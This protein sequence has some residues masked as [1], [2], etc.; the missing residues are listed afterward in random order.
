M[1]DKRQLKLIKKLFNIEKTYDINS[2]EEAILEEELLDLFEEE[3]LDKNFRSNVMELINK[4]EVEFKNKKLRKNK[5]SLIAACAVII[6]LIIILP[7]NK[8]IVDALEQWVRNITISNKNISQTFKSVEDI[9]SLIDRNEEGKLDEYEKMKMFRPICRKEYTN[10]NSK[11]AEEYLKNESII[12]LYKVGDLELHNMRYQEYNNYKSFEYHFLRRIDKNMEDYGNVNVVIGQ[13]EEVF[14]NM[15]T[16]SKNSEFKKVK[17]LSYEGVFENTTSE[18][19]SKWA[20]SKSIIVPI[21]EEKIEVRLEFQNYLSEN[22]EKEVIKMMEQIIKEIKRNK[23]L[24]VVTEKKYDTAKEG[25][26]YIK[27]QSIIELYELLGIQ[28]DSMEYKKYT[29]K[30]KF[31]YLYIDKNLEATSSKSIN[32]ISIDITKYNKNNSS[33]ISVPVSNFE[34]V[35]ILSYDGIFM[36]PFDDGECLE[37]Y[38]PDKK[39][40][41]HLSSTN[42][43]NKVDAIKAM[44]TI[45]RD[46]SK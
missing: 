12:Q 3:I 36:T 20:Y 17:V 23:N 5:K 11:E 13:H 9:E 39:I 7:Y 44:E 22:F 14:T 46:I 15:T 1:H 28:L 40:K 4:E 41:I 16:Y 33:N 42:Y 43:I 24:K 30:E 19:E 32:N 35:K 8:V 29:T 45:I 21:P 6:A 34:K 38:M 31:S 27:E 10:I 26:K 25:E 37:L 18:Y 2:E